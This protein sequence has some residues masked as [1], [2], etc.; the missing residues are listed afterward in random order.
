MRTIIAILLIFACASAVAQ[1]CTVD[2]PGFDSAYNGDPTVQLNDFGR[3]HYDAD[4]PACAEA[5][6]YALINKVKNTLAAPSTGDINDRI[7]GWL[8]SF[9]VGLIFAAALRLG[10]NGWASKDIDYHYSVDGSPILRGIETEVA[11]RGFYLDNTCRREFN[12]CIED[13]AGIASAYAWMAAYKYRRGDAASEVENFRALARENIRKALDYENLY[14]ENA[15]CIHNPSVFASNPN[16]F[17]NGTL[18]ELQNGTA[19]TMTVNTSQVQSPTYGF[20]QMSS[21]ASAV[22]GLDAAGSGYVFNAAQ[23]A[24]ARGL[25]EEMQRHVDTNPYPDVFRSDCPQVLGG[26]PFTISGEYH[27]GANKYFPQM[28]RLDKFYNDYLGG[29]P[30]AGAYRS[31]DV[32]LPHYDLGPFARFI[33]FTF[34]RHEAWVKHGYD[35]HVAPRQ[36]MPHDSYN[37]IGWFDGVWQIE[38]VAVGWACDQD[39]PDGRVKVT[40]YANDTWDLVAEGWADQSSEAAVNSACG[41]GSAHRFFIPLPSWSRGMNLRVYGLDYTWYGHTEL[42]CNGTSPCTWEVPFRVSLQTTTGHYWRAEYGGGGNIDAISTWPG[43]H[44]TFTIID[45]NG[46]QLVSGDPV[47][48]LTSSG[49]YYVSA[50]GGGGGYLFA[51]Y[52]WASTWET[53]TI[54]KLNGSGAITQTDQIA[55][56]AYNGQ[57]VSADNGGGGVVYAAF[58]WI[59]SWETFTLSPQQ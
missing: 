1:N 50:D 39:K 20:G 40:I 25:F 44:E 29:I 42:A 3:I 37:P 6:L 2:V 36:Y 5:A 13:Y 19:F 31:D 43:L 22:L 30:N 8:R 28:F 12:T 47:H 18:S 7:T 4:N 45:A 23:R 52:P 48:L 58:P 49:Y 34:G 11:T 55:L 59:G 41:G 32:Y 16:A 24:V 35:W 53:F 9:Q 57:Y 14:G 38:G 56:Q 26:P 33:D 15:V 54:H 21:I 46:G 17:C 51:L 27:C 10:A